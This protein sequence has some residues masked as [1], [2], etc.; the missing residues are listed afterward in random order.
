MRMDRRLLITA[1]GT[2]LTLASLPLRAGETVSPLYVDL[3]KNT[4]EP[5]LPMAN[6]ARAAGVVLVPRID[7]NALPNRTSTVILGIP[8]L[9]EQPESGEARKQVLRNTTKVPTLTAP[10]T[11]RIIDCSR[12]PL[13]SLPDGAQVSRSS[14]PFFTVT[15]NATSVEIYADQAVVPITVTDVTG[16]K[17]AHF[18]LEIVNRINH[19]YWSLG[20]AFLGNRDSEFR[21]E[22]AGDGKQRIVEAGSGGVPYR[23]A[24]FAHYS[25]YPWRSG[26]V[27][28]SFGLGTDVPVSDLAALAGVT[29][30][31]KTLP[32]VDSGHVTLGASYANRQVL[33]PEYRGSP[34]VESPVTA[35]GLTTGKKSFAFFAAFTF[36]FLGGEEEFRAVVEGRKGRNQ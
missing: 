23:L 13:P 2:A 17:T 16:E 3:D 21:L 8:F 19:L 20:F 33:R 24:A 36:S 31:S 10:L 32:V 35:A 4:T 26:G 29:I 1:C 30:T 12:A 5:A 27:A 28:L 6:S 9:G 18:A 14:C 15:S 34:L 22:P 11:L 7:G 25:V